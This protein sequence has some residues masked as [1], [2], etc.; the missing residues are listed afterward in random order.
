MSPP[1]A[2]IDNHAQHF[3]IYVDA[4]GLRSLCLQDKASL[5]EQAPAPVPYIS[6]TLPFLFFVIY[7][8]LFLQSQVAQT[9]LEVTTWLTDGDDL[10][11][12][13]LL[14]PRPGHWDYRLVQPCRFMQSWGR[15]F[16]HALDLPVTRTRMHGTRTHR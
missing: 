15:T 4:G 7:F 8:I 16:V 1:S 10:E 12:Q 11:L 13:L 3:N 9:V 14:S 5:T 2:E 6:Y